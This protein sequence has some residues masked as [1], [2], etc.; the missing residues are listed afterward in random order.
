MWLLWM[1]LVTDLVKI[2]VTP[3]YTLFGLLLTPVFIMH[4]TTTIHS[5]YF[6]ITFLLSLSIH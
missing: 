2:R 3:L 5:F 6:G 4:Y 1:G